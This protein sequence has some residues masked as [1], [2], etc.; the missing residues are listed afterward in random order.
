MNGPM[1]SKGAEQSRRR[2]ARGST[3]HAGGGEAGQGPVRQARERIL[4]DWDRIAAGWMAEWDEGA[5][6]LTEIADQVE[7]IR[8]GT[9][10]DGPMPAVSRPVLYCRLADALRDEILRSWT[11]AGEEPRPRQAPE[12]LLDTLAALATYRAR[13]WTKGD[14]DFAARLL[15]P[16]AF[17]LVVELAHDIRSPLN[18]ILFLSEVLRSGHSGPVND[19]QRSQLGLMYSATLGL[20]SVVSDVM[21]LAS[22][23]RGS[24][25]EEATPFSIGRVFESVHEMVRP[26]AEEKELSLE[27][28]LPDYDQCV[29]FP[30]RLGRVLLNLT[31][32]ALKFTEEGGVTIAAERLGQNRMEFA[33]ADTGRGISQEQLEVLFQPFR[34][35]AYRNGYFFSGSGLGLSIARRLI[36]TMDSDLNVRTEVGKGSRFSFELE[37][38]PPSAVQ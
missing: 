35:S 6:G 1:P 25:D 27:F 33:V 32:N 38:P 36:R 2:V 14:E 28:R 5:E 7:R 10:S 4:D 21:E 31:T 34:K 17:E 19:H 30:N 22:E 12:T 16:D 26:M 13:I 18:S 37:L 8:S 29:G 20:I 15:E 23:R 11:P 24:D 9:R 3:P